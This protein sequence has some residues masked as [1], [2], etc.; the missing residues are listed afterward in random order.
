MNEWFRSAFG[1]HYLKVYAHRDDTEARQAVDWVVRQVRLRPNARVLDAP[2]GAG[3][4]A[5]ALAELGLRVVGLD[6]SREL[7][8]EGRIQSHEGRSIEWLRAD[9]RAL[10]LA[11]GVFHAIFNFFSSFGYFHEDRENQQV[12]KEFARVLVPGG[13]LVL[14]FMNEPYV[15][16]HLVPASERH[17]EQG[18]TVRET[19]GIEGDPPRVVKRTQLR[20]PDGTC[21]TWLESVRLYTPAE[22]RA[23]LDTAGFAITGLFGDYRGAPWTRSTPR[24]IF[25][26]SQ[27]SDS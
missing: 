3:R 7:L 25:I 23:M 13:V 15:R 2:C 16:A 26:A 20:L 18:W 24:A 17:T 14:D 27:R 4:H 12:L 9:I 6:L 11:Q 5:R 19:R 10:P 8:H 21:R 22:L 1:V